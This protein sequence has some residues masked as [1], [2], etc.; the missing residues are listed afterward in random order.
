MYY[1]DMKLLGLK[2]E[3]KKSVNFI[4]K[5]GTVASETTQQRRMLRGQLLSSGKI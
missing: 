1:Y 5:K 4:G 2:K 3:R